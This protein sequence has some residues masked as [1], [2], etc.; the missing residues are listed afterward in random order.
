MVSSKSRS[1]HL[2]QTIVV[3]F[4]EGL[5]R[6]STFGRK[7]LFENPN[8]C[9]AIQIRSKME[10]RLDRLHQLLARQRSGVQI[11]V[12]KFRVSKNRGKFLRNFLDL[13]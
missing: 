7:H 10:G 11:S 4:N 13:P 6:S 1:V 12:P 2:F 5:L 3:F 9:F 8:S